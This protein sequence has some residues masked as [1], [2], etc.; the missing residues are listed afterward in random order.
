M[1]PETRPVDSHDRDLARA[2][3]TNNYIVEA[4]AGTG[5][6]TL[7][8]DRIL[9]LILRERAAPEDIVAITFTER[10]AAELK[11][12]LQD[13]LGKALKRAQDDPRAEDAQHLAEALWAFERMQVTTIHSFCATL[14][15]ERPVEA[16]IDPNF[17][18]ADALMASLIGDETWEDWLAGEMDRDDAVLRRA[19]LLGVTLE[20]MC[21][22]ARAMVENRDMLDHLPEPS[23]SCIVSAPGQSTARLALR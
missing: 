13:E 23:P 16:G 8:V 15:R 20:N 9:N 19:V 2:D 10:A 1:N 6:T 18:V 17:E 3:L 22:L 5:K 12:K 14:L 7:L 4:A 21:K 11:M